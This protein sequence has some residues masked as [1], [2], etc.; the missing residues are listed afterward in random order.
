MSVKKVQVGNIECGSDEL[1]V[2]SGPC[3]IED[4]STM[5]SVMGINFI[6]NVIIGKSI[7]IEIVKNNKTLL[8]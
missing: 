6:K 1:F 8:Y 4:E 3:V 7:T 2:I 5:M